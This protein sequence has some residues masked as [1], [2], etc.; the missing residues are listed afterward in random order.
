LPQT[1]L[2][3]ELTAIF[4]ILLSCLEQDGDN[5]HLENNVIHRIAECLDKIYTKRCE[6]IRFRSNTDRLIG[7]RLKNEQRNY[8][9]ERIVLGKTKRLQKKLNRGSPIES[10]RGLYESII[11][12]CFY[13]DQG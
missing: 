5:T 6:E 4:E 7:T 8:S 11:K 1:Q 12:L 9:E 3:D 13:Y 10:N 2:P